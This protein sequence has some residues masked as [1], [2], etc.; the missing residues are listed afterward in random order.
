MV[1]EDAEKDEGTE[2][3]KPEMPNLK[4]DMTVIPFPSR[5]RNTKH[6]IE[7]EDIMEFFQMV[8]VNILLLDIIQHIPHYAKFLKIYAT[9]RKI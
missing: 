2:T 1:D 9:Q 7:D 4:E 3:P 5:L 8:E 6:K